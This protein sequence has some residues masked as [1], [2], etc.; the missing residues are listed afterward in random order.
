[1]EGRAIA[2][3]NLRWCQR[4]P[5]QRHASMEGRAIARPNGETAAARPCELR[6]ASMEGRAIA[7]PNRVCFR[8]E[9]RWAPMLQWRA[10]Q[11][12]GQTG[13]LGCGS[14]SAARCFNGGPGNCPAKLV[15]I[16][17]RKDLADLLQWRAGQL[18]GQ[19]VHETEVDG[20]V[21]LASMEGRAIARPNLVAGDELDDR[22]A[23]SMEG[24]AIA[25]P[26]RR[27]H[28][29]PHRLSV[30]FNGGPG[31]CPAK[32]RWPTRR[33]RRPSC[34]NGGPGN[35]PAKLGISPPFCCGASASMEGR[36]IARP[37]PT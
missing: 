24:R 4:G 32:L 33:C 17:W 27:R 1:M 28:G 11:L 18:P 9:P 6:T 21:D 20:G 35:C 16:R 23:A 30:C 25:R 8:M 2:R 29:H 26:N 34:F 19:T 7:R 14:G 12:P 37:N 36:A 10:G 3:P 22:P 31:N 5:W 13:R 15:C